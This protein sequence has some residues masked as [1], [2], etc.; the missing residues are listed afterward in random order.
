MA[1]N[2]KFVTYKCNT[3]NRTKDVEA[4]SLHSF[5][6]LCSIT[7][8]C[9]GKLLPI[10]TKSL[11]NVL[12]SAPVDGVPDWISRFEISRNQTSSTINSS[13]QNLYVTLASSSSLALSLAVKRQNPS[14]NNNPS[15]LSISFATQQ[16]EV[17]TFDEFTYFIS[18]TFNSV[19][20]P[21]STSSKKVLRFTSS[22]IV[23]VFLNGVEL[24]EGTLINDYRLNYNGQNG[25]Q[26]VF[27]TSYSISSV[28]KVIVYQNQNIVL[29]NPIT[30]TR[31]TLLVSNLENQTSWTNVSTIE[32]GNDTYDVYTCL[33]TLSLPA[34]QILNLYPNGNHFS[35]NV[36]YTDLNNFR[37]L[38]AYPPFSVIDRIYSAFVDF[39]NLSDVD[40]HLRLYSNNGSITLEVSKNSIS[41]VSFAPLIHV[42]DDN[43]E[44]LSSADVITD[45]TSLIPNNPKII[46]PI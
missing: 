19:S 11:R 1:A 29:S 12:A 17:N 13:E 33:D 10:A 37:F 43:L 3:C 8:N 38:L 21:D 26:V 41:Y 2:K 16:S 23:K 24:I 32:Y 20:G 44:W 40:Y 30:F 42:A 46:G 9:S 15:S 45:D 39:N 4:S 5:I 14:I 28:V 25:Y 22:D 35:S 31:N 18:S 36:I 6:N 34:N 7:L 27:N